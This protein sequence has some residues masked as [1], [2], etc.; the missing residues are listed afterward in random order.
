MTWN[1]G[2][3]I[4]HNPLGS[5]SDVESFRLEGEA[6]V[7]FH[8]GRM[9]MEHTLDTAEGQ[10]ANL[11]FWCQE[12]FGSD[13]AV[14]WDFWPLQEPGLCMLFLAATGRG[15]ED[16]FDPALVRRSGEYHQYRHGDINALHVS[17]FCRMPKVRWFHACHFRKSYGGHLVARGAD[18]ILASTTLRPRT[19]CHSSSAGPTSHSRSMSCP[20]SNGTTTVWPTGQSWAAGRSAFGRWRQWWRNTPTSRFIA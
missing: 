18:P 4:Y 5:D 20:S 14:S 1:I 3:Q 6:K 7:S 19:T 17:Y 10:R 11:V 8:D 12:D 2:D 15:G 9:R 16:I 13:L